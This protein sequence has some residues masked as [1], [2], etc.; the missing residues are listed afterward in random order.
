MNKKDERTARPLRPQKL[1]RKVLLPML[2]IVV[3]QMVLIASIVYGSGAI[4][5]LD[6]SAL[7]MLGRN[8]DARRDNLQ[9]QMLK[10]SDLNDALFQIESFLSHTA[11]TF[12]MDDKGILLNK[13]QRASLLRNVSNEVISLLRDSGATGAFIILENE[14]GDNE[15]DAFYVRTQSPGSRRDNNSDLLGEAGPASIM[16]GLSITFDSYWGN[17]YTL[18][19]NA[20]FF[21]RPL[22]A[23]RE[24]T[25]IAS[26]DLGYWSQPFRPRAQDI[27]V[28]TYTVPLRNEYHQPFGVLGIEI[29]LT[30]LAAQ[31]PS[32]ELGIDSGG[33]Y[34]LAVT[35][36][37]KRYTT[38]LA[39]GSYYQSKLPF[40]TQLN[41]S[42]NAHYNAFHSLELEGLPPTY[43]ATAPLTLYNTNTPFIH[44]KWVLC[45]LGRAAA[46]EEYSQDRKSVV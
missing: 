27:A 5:Q 34:L 16:R 22:E 11:S 41:M 39:Q 26:G 32:R 13:D 14:T 45:G 23:A 38:V 35:E 30:H 7:Q 36:D 8:V 25:D 2:A 1:R 6:Q 17:R 42:Q 24:Y 29:S 21:Y 28:I 40:G 10:W 46:I 37:E 43:A 18:P 33:S 3:L 15:K 4:T 20:D 31:L 9:A 12:N 44:E 19:E